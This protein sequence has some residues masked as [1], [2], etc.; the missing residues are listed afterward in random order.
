MARM[1]KITTAAMVARCLNA[2]CEKFGVKGETHEVRPDVR[3]TDRY[4]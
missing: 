3:T 2:F 4:W 1:R